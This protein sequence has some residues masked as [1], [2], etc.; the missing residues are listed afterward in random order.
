M[1][2]PRGDAELAAEAPK[3]LTRLGRHL[4][5]VEQG[6]EGA[7]DD[8]AAVLRILIDGSNRGNRGMARL[9]KALGV[10]IPTVLVSGPPT[11]NADRGLMLAFGNLPSF[12]TP[13]DGHLHAPH[14]MTFEDWMD[15]PSLIVPGS[16]KR[17]MSWG[18]FAALVANTDGSHLSVEYHDLLET[19]DLFN[20]V[21]LSLRDYLL[22]QVGWAVEQAL[23]MMII[24]SGKPL[25]PRTRRLDYWGRAPIWLLFRDQPGKGM[26][27]A[28]S[29]EVT[30]DDPTPVEI[31][32]FQWRGRTNHIYHD[33][34]DP[35]AGGPRVRLVVD[36]PVTG[37]GVTT[38]GNQLD[39]A[40]P[41]PLEL[42]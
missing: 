13:G 35:N 9:A 14:M 1:P 22:R 25:L 7:G 39:P 12:N 34:G 24:A 40:D 41:P 6:E 11:L 23:A 27:A 42:D 18:G 32:R 4:S 30:S 2:T 16:E 17:R 36:D 15:A 28:V 21:G 10:P 19:S 8:L 33:G 26:E 29:V 38:H 5:A 20:A 3:L 37:E 31:M